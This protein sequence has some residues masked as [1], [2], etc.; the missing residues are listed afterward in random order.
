MTMP[1]S[2]FKT[3]MVL[4]NSYKEVHISNQNSYEQTLDSDSTR[5]E[6]SL[7]IPFTT[8]V[9]LGK[10]PKYSVSAFSSIK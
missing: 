10:R 2:S 1:F 6:P 9:T 5:F 7:S 4:Y 3:I 8:C